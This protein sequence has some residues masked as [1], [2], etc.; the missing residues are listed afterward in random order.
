VAAVFGRDRD[1]FVTNLL[2]E[3]RELAGRKGFD[4]GWAVNGFEKSGGR[5]VHQV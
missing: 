1:D 2:R 5:N 4:V 3:L